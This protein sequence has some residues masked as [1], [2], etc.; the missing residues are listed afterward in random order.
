MNFSGSGIGVFVFLSVW[1]MNQLLVFS[2]SASKVMRRSAALHLC[3]TSFYFCPI[4]GRLEMDVLIITIMN[5]SPTTP[6]K[7]NNLLEGKN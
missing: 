3:N 5:L 1:H 2:F 7:K 4:S 6:C